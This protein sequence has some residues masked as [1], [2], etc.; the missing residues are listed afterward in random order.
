L[1]CAANHRVVIHENAIQNVSFRVRGFWLARR[2]KVIRGVTR[3]DFF[4]AR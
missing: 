2:E 4:Q 1:R 3:Q